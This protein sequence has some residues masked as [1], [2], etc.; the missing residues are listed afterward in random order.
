MYPLADQAETSKLRTPPQPD[1]P[2]VQ[3][4][5]S[6]FFRAVVWTLEDWPPAGWTETKSWDGS[7]TLT[8][9]AAWC[10]GH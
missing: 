1:P 10:K 7:A 5:I 2:P 8:H 6:L 3:C 4:T 9:F